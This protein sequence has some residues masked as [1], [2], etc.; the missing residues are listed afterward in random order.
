MRV[1][2]KIGDP[3]CSTLLNSRSLCISLLCAGIEARIE[4]SWTAET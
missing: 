1:F 2:R 3:I 4:D